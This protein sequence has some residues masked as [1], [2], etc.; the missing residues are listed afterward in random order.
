MFLKRLLALVLC[1]LTAASLF[2]AFAAENDA[3]AVPVK[4]PSAILVHPSGRVLY[5][6]NADERRPPASVTKIMTLLLVMEG[7]EN[8]SLSYDDIITGSAYATSMGGSQ[9]W[10]KE[11]ESFTLR[12]MIKCVA[13]ASAND[14]SVAIA[15]HI[16][17][18]E[19]AFVAMMNKRAAELGMKD[20]SFVNCTGLEADGH[21]TT[22][23]DISVM[24][25]ELLKHREITEFTTIWMDTIRDGAFGLTNTNRMIKTYSGM[26][27]LKTGYIKQA[28]Y[29]LSGAAERDGM[30]LIAVVLGGESSVSR[31]QDVAALLNYGFAN[32]T[33]TNLTSDEPL[34]PVKVELGKSGYVAVLPQGDGEVLIKKSQL[35]SLEKR[36]E[37]AESVPAPVSEGDEL[38]SFKVYSGGEAILSV[39][40]VAAEGVE[41]MTVGDLWGLILSSAFMRG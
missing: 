25:R 3:E 12:E 27:G 28:G 23:R 33:Q 34:M 11:G 41:R 36:V 22:A 13:V 14:C 32:Y 39:P 19:E 30:T 20:T 2:T 38:G 1:L 17:G 31:N 18:S 26:I 5:E 21:Y 37:L 35:G 16:A 8:G 10:L 9:I 4:A 7:L 15:E 6:K 29:C 40:I 24:S